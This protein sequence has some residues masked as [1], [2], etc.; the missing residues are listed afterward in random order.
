MGTSKDGSGS[1]DRSPLIPDHADAE[2]NQ[3]APPRDPNA[4]RKYRLAITRYVRS[5]NTDDRRAVL[6][7][8]ASNAVGGSSHGYRRQGATAKAGG[9]AIA[10]IGDLGRGGTG[11]AATGSDLRAAIGKPI[12]EA[13]QIIA[14]AVAPENQD[15]DEI[16]AAIQDAICEVLSEEPA[17]DPSAMTE[18]QFHDLLATYVTLCVFHDLWFREAGASVNRYASPEALIDREND[19]RETVRATVDN[20]LSQRAGTPVSQMTADELRSLQLAV[21]QGTLEV[22]ESDA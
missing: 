14:E 19:L 9:S 1:N 3:P 16:R 12:E 11:Q 22:W 13:A 8:Y 20:V 6:R 18:D 21:V 10:G 15:R 4:L 17:F 2:P 7:G 5:G